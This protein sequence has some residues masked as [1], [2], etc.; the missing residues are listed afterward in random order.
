VLNF[1]FLCFI[2]ISLFVLRSNFHAPTFRIIS[3]TDMRFVVCSFFF[4]LSK[5]V[6]FYAARGNCCRVLLFWPLG[7]NFTLLPTSIHLWLHVYWS[8]VQFLFRHISRIIDGY[9]ASATRRSECG[10]RQ[11]I[12]A[13][14]I[15]HC[16]VFLHSFFVMTACC[17]V[18][19]LDPRLLL[20]NFSAVTLLL[21]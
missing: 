5:R 9:L 20:G 4:Y 6:W 3:H 11:G 18:A 7:T 10:S 1:R 8:T 13:C 14:W 12:I 19:Y 21:V 2:C 16:L 15:C 17:A